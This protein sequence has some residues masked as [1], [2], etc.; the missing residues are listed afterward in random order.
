MS[1]RILA[2]GDVHG[3]SLALDALLDTARP[4]RSGRL[5]VCGHS[6]QRSGAIADLGHTICIDTAIAWGVRLTCLALPERRFWQASPDGRVRRGAL[7]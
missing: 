5:V 4:H 2:I 7:P 3:H 1:E 6:S